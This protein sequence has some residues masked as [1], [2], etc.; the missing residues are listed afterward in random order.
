[1]VR[2]AGDSGLRATI[3]YRDYRSDDLS[4]VLKP[5]GGRVVSEPAATALPTT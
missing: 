2:P 5:S 1:M 3:L 4:D